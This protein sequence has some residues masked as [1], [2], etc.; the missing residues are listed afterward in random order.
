MAKLNRIGNVERLVK[1]LREEDETCLGQL[2]ARDELSAGFGNIYRGGDDYF[3]MQAIADLI[4]EAMG[5]DGFN[6][7]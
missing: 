2:K 4:E 6:R 3:A 1:A 5:K 7:Q